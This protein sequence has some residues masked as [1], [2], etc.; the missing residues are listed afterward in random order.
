ME[1]KGRKGLFSFLPTKGHRLSEGRELMY[2]RQT[3]CSA[4]EASVWIILHDLLHD[5]NRGNGGKNYKNGRQTLK[6]D[7]TLGIKS[8]SICFCWEV[9]V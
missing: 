9:M 1:T 7:F 4:L 5:Y 2:C 6:Q 3:N 8:I